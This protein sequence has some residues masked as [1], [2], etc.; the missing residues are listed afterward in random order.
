M[1]NAMENLL[2][3]L[4]KVRREVGFADYKHKEYG[5]V[6]CVFNYRLLLD[7]KQRLE[8][9]IGGYNAERTIN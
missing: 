2:A 1:D 7:K 9:A 3:E 4:A 5:L 8:M 6:P